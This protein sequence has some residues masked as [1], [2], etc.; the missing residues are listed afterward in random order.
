MRRGRSALLVSAL[1]HVAL[2]AALAQVV[3]AGKKVPPLASPAEPEP[4]EVVMLSPPAV[5]PTAR[6]DD[7]ARV[8][9]AHVASSAHVG[10]AH[11]DVAAHVD[12]ARVA[13][14]DVG[15]HGDVP[16]APTG[17][18]A[19][20]PRGDQGS[21]Y[22]HMR[23]PDLTLDGS[24]AERIAAGGDHSLPG[25]PK[26][27]GKLENVSGGGAVI[28]D[29]VT[30][31]DVERDG[32]AHFHDKKDIDV[33]L[34]LP[35]PHLDF[36]GMRKDLG[37]ALTDWYADPYAA[38]KFGRYQDLSRINQAVPGACDEWG[39]VACDDPLAPDAEKYVREQKKTNGSI[40]GGT[41]DISAYLQRKYVGDPY[42]S[43]K[44]KLLDDTR[45]E[46]VARGT[47]FREQQLVR[48]A[49]LIARNLARL[50]AARLPTADLHEVLFEL[51]DECGEGEGE[52]GQAGQRA[53]AQVLGWIGAHLPKG[54]PQA[55]SDEEI[56]RFDARRGSKQRFQPY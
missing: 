19:T 53:R 23:G 26:I 51:W 24:T 14:S 40:A 30:T 52:E 2:F 11:V 44:L 18:S 12:P 28:H 6:V 35:T 9:P 37:K 45:D 1:A 20:N 54:S 50:A 41:A 16:G 27:T 49:E 47:A 34:K 38:T 13:S 15:S 42:A 5:D 31:V 8:A 36:E 43:R 21:G 3:V 25:E 56:A 7:A 32:T 29:R 17:A 46:R 22:M 48:S 33:K 55:F 4:I 10:P 39:S